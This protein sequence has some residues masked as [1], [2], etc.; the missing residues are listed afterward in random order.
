MLSLSLLTKLT[1]TGLCAIIIPVAQSGSAVRD[2]SATFHLVLYSLS[3]SSLSPF[4]SLSKRSMAVI[5]SLSFSPV[6]IL[7]SFIKCLARECWAVEALTPSIEM[8][9]SP[10]SRCVCSVSVLFVRRSG[11]AGVSLY[12]S[13]C[14]PCGLCTLRNP[15]YQIQTLCPSGGPKSLT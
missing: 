5:N 2:N 12:G 7:L 10:A 9:S 4:Y 11:S 13:F 14:N 15:G 1:P 6:L 3:L 8:L